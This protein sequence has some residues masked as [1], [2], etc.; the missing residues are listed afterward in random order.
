[1]LTE[2]ACVDL[3]NLFAQGE[4]PRRCLV[5]EVTIEMAFVRIQ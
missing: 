5:L 2:L 4:E 3:W 1:M